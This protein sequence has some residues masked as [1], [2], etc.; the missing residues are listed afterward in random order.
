MLS[1]GCCV[2]AAQRQPKQRRLC[3]SLDWSFSESGWVGTPGSQ[4]ELQC[5]RCSGGT[6][7]QQKQAVIRRSRNDP[8]GT[9]QCTQF[10]DVMVLQGKPKRLPFRQK[11]FF[12][13]TEQCIKSVVVVPKCLQNE[14]LKTPQSF[15]NKHELL[16][17]EYILS[18]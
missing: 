7:Q 4:C 9:D 5:F 6:G 1:I 13:R 14:S 12:L 18:T 10:S 11:G 3:F 17:S 2:D 8:L 16:R 15:S